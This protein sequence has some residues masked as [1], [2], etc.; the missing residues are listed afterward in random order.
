MVKT[1]IFDLGNV[2]I[3]VNQKLMFE[4]FTKNSGKPLNE[5]EKI[6]ENS[7]DRRKFEMGKL[8]PT[9][10]YNLMKKGMN[11]NLSF[12]EF[13]KVYT[14][15]FSHNKEIEKIIPKLKKNYRLVL[16]SNT[17]E[18]H[19]SFIRKNF[20][21]LNYFNDFVLSYKFGCRKPNPLIFLEAIKKSRTYPWNCAYFDDIKEFVWVARMM[22]VKAFQYKSIEKL[23][24]DLK[25]L[26][27]LG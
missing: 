17:D 26:G 27:I 16:L 19:Y 11:L 8:N 23:K 2:V 5:I 13:R 20:N 1:I 22:G 15:M 21:V 3:N 25:K 7:A 10:F 18:L 6:Y 14:C 12:D 9:Q 24:S 4:K